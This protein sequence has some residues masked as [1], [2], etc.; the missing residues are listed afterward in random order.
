MV[1]PGDV[2]L[3]TRRTSER[4]MFLKP[5]PAVTHIF[6]Y[7]L[8]WA[9]TLFKIRLLAAYVGSNH[10]HLVV[11]DPNKVVSDFAEQLDGMVARVLNYH[12]KRVKAAFWNNQGLSLVKLVDA[13]AII[14]KAAYC[15]ANP[16]Q[17]GLIEDPADW[18]G[19]WLTAKD[20]GKMLTF[21]RPKSKFFGKRSKMPKEATLTLGLPPQLEHL[22]I[23]EY[24]KKH[25]E[26]LASKVDAAVAARKASGGKF[27]GLKAI[28][29]TR[30]TQRARRKEKSGARNTIN[31]R[32]AAGCNQAR[33]RALLVLKAFD[34]AY[35]DALKRYSEGERDVV[36]PAGTYMMKRRFNVRVEGADEA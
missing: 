18:P 13:D 10:F 16:T 5:G 25:D 12:W 1:L 3:M 2:W 22:S 35:A 14:D 33:I 34:V 21:T 6:L 36:F 17:D 19:V 4:R 26:M 15:A 30:H 31:P 7:L 8:A 9:A 29:K 11:Y 23:D 32:I 20:L 28:A 27:L 24:V